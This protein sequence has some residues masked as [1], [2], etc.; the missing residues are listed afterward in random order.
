MRL[1]VEQFRCWRRERRADFDE[2]VGSNKRRAHC[3][4][5]G[6][7]LEASEGVGYVELMSDFFSRLESVHLPPLRGANSTLPMKWLIE[8]VVNLVYPPEEGERPIP[9]GR[10]LVVFIFLVLIVLFA[11]LVF[12]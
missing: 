3:R 6:M 2:P 8:M 1:S 9:F 12:R 5:C 7:V 11:F 4:L 10:V